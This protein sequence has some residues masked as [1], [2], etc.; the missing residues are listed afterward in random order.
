MSDL[1]NGL[2]VMTPDSIDY[3]GTSA[4]IN[5]DG[6]INAVGVS[7]LSL[8]NVFTSEY[9]NYMIVGSVSGAV[10]TLQC[11]LR[12]GGVDNSTATSYPHQ[13]ISANGSAYGANRVTGNNYWRIVTYGVE[14][15]S[16]FTSYIFGPQLS[17]ATAM[18]SVSVLSGSGS[19]EIA[20]WAGT[21]TVSAAYDGCS[22]INSS[23][24]LKLTVFG[25]NQ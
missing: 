5:S 1:I 7:S 21:H 9:D 24:F 13:N 20:D 25:F 17:Q 18:R 11:R 19:P 2:V 6:S 22:F 12:V 10:T 23:N 16:S 4:T 15:G 3:V 8:N 14:K